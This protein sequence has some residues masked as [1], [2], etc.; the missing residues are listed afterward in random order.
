V[1][2]VEIPSSPRIAWIGVGAAGGYY[3]ARLARAGADLHLL[4]RSDYDVVKRQ[5]LRIRSHAGDFSVA[6]ESL[7]L[8]EKAAAM[9]VADLVIVTVKT[10]ANAQLPELIRPL[11]H[12]RT[13]VLT[14]QNGLGNEELLADIVGADRVL[15]GVMFT[16]ITRPEPGII[17]HQAQG[18]IRIGEFGRP[19][20]ERT[21]A[22]CRMFNA[23]GIECDVGESLA[24]V[25]WAK[26]LWNVPFN[27]LGAAF[28]LPTDGLIDSKFGRELLRGVMGEVREIAG[29]AGVHLPGALID[30]QIELTGPMGSYRTSMHLDRLAGRQMEIEA[31]IGRPIAI[32]RR[33]QV[34]CQHLRVI[35]SILNNFPYLKY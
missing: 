32:A 33:H 9:P 12:E 17:H 13:L 16:C 4:L 22:I 30:R 18:Q 26:Q 15:G 24:Q 11:L 34:H 31:I 14:L 3:A 23:A 7:N 1:M 8:Y 20:T 19:P 25:R 6:P 27:G 29:A 21:H 35:Y 28:D 2:V 10:T 5:G